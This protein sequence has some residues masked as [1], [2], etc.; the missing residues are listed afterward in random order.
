M[1]LFALNTGVRQEELCGLRWDWEIAVPELETSVFILPGRRRAVG[2]PQIRVHDLRRSFGRRRRAAGV[3]P[4]QEDRRNHDAL[5]GT[6]AR[7]PDRGRR[8]S[9]R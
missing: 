5:L 4:G 3:L 1:A 7:G 6:R 2:L 8:E 9:V